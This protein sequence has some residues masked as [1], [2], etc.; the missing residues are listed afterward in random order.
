MKSS[1]QVFAALVA[2]FATL[3]QSAIATSTQILPQHSMD[4]HY[5]LLSLGSMIFS[6]TQAEVRSTDRSK[7]ASLKS[8]FDNLSADVLENKCYAKQIDLNKD[9]KDE[10]FI[11][12]TEAAS[13]GGGGRCSFTIERRQG[14]KYQTI[15][16]GITTSPDFAVLGSRTN[17][18]R[19]IATRSYLGKEFWSVWK[20][21]G[22]EYRVIAHKDIESIS[23][24]KIT[25]L[26]PCS[27]IFS[28]K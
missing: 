15:L 6:S 28:N 16:G 10:V 4:G 14:N 18:W 26:K 27:E 25:K 2:A 11:R 12:T 1:T 22:K 23:N 19:D 3:S 8:L 21:D 7:K 13:C 5:S 9:G 20:F 24:S 17:G